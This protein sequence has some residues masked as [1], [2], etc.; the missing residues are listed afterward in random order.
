MIRELMRSKPVTISARLFLAVAVTTFLLAGM[1]GAAAAAPSDAA[2]D[3]PAAEK[4]HPQQDKE[5]DHQRDEN[6]DGGESD[7]KALS[8]LG[9]ACQTPASDS[10]EGS[11]WCR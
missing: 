3:N 8:G 1:A 10:P 7:T 4:D 9:S 11:T 6:Y 5:Q 2:S